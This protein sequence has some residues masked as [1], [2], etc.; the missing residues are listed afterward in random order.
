VEISLGQELLTEEEGK[1]LYDLRLKTVADLPGEASEGEEHSAGS[2]S[3]Y[4][5][6][7]DADGEIESCR[8]A[9]D[10]LCYRAANVV[11][12]LQGGGIEA[13]QLGKAIE[14]LAEE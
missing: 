9:A 8:A 3:V 14:R 2:L 6:S 13:Q 5:D 1:E 12:V 7:D 10:L 4:E 11:V